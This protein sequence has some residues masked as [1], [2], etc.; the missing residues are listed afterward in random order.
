MVFNYIGI[1]IGYY[2]V[3]VIVDVYMKGDCNFDI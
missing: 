3:F 1:M 2:V